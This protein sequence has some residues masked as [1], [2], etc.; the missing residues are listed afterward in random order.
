MSISIET[1]HEVCF[2]NCNVSGIKFMLGVVY[3]P[4]WL[5]RN[6]N[7]ELY[8]V[9]R[10][11]LRHTDCYCITGDFNFPDI[12]WSRMSS[13]DSEEKHFLQ[14]LNEE[15]MI[16]H[17]FESTRENSILDLCLTPNDD[18]VSDLK[19]HETFSTSDHSYITFNFNLPF[20]F[21][22]KKFTYRD[23]ENVD[24]EL[25]RAHLAIIDWDIYFDGYNDDCNM[26]WSIFHSIIDELMCE[27]VPVK[28]FSERKVAWLTPTL[29][30][31]YR[32]KKR[33]YRKW[34]NNPT[35][36]NL[37]EYK[38]YSRIVKTKVN[39]TKKHYERRK[40]HQ[41][42][43]KPKQFYNYIKS[44][45]KTSE[46][47]A[48]LIDNERDRLVTLDSEKAELLRRQYCSVFTRDNGV[49]PDCPQTVL[50]D[51]ICDIS[52][53]DCDIIRAIRQMNSN[54]APGPDGIHPKFINNIYPF[55]IKPLKRIFNLSLSTGVV[56]NS[57]KFSEVIPIYKN[58]R[59]PNNC[60]SY[61]PVCLTSYISKILEKIIHT[62]LLVYLRESNIISKSQHGFLSRKSTTTNLLECLDDWTLELDKHHKLD[63]MYIDLEKA[64][65]SLS[66]EKL[67]YKLSKIGIGGNLH[68]WFS[69][70]L[71]GRCFWVKVDGSRSASSTV[72]SGIPQGTILGPLLFILFINNVSE[73]LVHSKI[74]LYAD[75]SKLYGDATTIEQCQAFERDI[76]AVNDWLQS[77]QLR[78][79][80]EK[81]EV[82]HFSRYPLEFSYKVNNRVVPAKDFCRDLGV[83]VDKGLTFHRH[84]LNVARIAHWKSKLFFKAFSCQDYDFYVF[85]FTTY[86]R[87]IVESATQVWNPH[88]IQNIDII[89]NVQRRFTKFLPGLFN[90]PYLTRLQT[91]NLK[92]LE[93]RRIINDIIFIFKII[94]HLVDLPFDKYFSFNRN[95]TRGHS[96]KLNL[97]HSR[98]DCRRYFFSNRC[99][100]VWNNKLTENEVNI[101]S[102]NSFKKAIDKINFSSYCRGRAFVV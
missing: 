77:W 8:N 59:K 31:M 100:D 39:D 44:R 19:V 16:Q 92:S 53:D 28:E 51:T 71:I 32:N 17:V 61:R 96:L 6:M 12:D 20:N 70:F 43:H 18:S 34:K 5:L 33:K 38:N 101:T 64:F 52:V 11:Q 102:L 56:P 95:N 74:Q 97:N 3:R 46:P 40:F 2:I 60:A 67:L 1:N 78:I 93:E 45:T 66:H 13:N 15:N 94:R 47:V 90:V 73:V 76:L 81:C 99:I 83:Y 65:D 72:V 24:Y 25:L 84:C 37:T 58:N 68:N 98:L 48:N 35:R 30:N 80:L 4:R 85:I 22:R 69:S 49:L 42:S 55:L 21:P 10:N 54:S 75:D 63:V 86:I 36:R 79:N 88:H 23:F 87:P 41:K 50:R 27:Y 9:I 57:W 89:E 91:L 7:Q 82:L 29:K 14:M 26:L 62:K